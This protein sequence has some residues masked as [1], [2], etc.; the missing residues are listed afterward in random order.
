MTDIHSCSYFCERPACIKAQRE[1]MRAEIERLQA[2][3]DA[4]EAQAVRNADEVLELRAELA[5][6]KAA[7]LVPTP[8]DYTML[9][10][11]ASI[12]RIGYNELCVV[13]L[14]SI[15]AAARGTT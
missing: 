13:V 8:L 2:E 1:E 11:F 6:L 15:E 12:N 9:Y 5:A 10:E 4:I 7:P 14:S 3:C